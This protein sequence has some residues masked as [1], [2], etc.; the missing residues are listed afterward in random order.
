M[1]T[2]RVLLSRAADVLL[3]R[4]RDDRLDEEIHMHL[5][6]LTD[7]YVARGL[8]PADAAHAARRSFGRVLQTK[9]EFRAQR[10]LPLLETI[11][12][13]VRFAIRLLGRDRA[14][15][16]TAVLVLAL[17][18]GVNNML[19]AI[20]NAHTLRGLPIPRA[21]R[22]AAITTINDQNQD[23]GLSHP[24]YEQ[25]RDAV[26]SFSGIV[27][28]AQAPVIL[29]GDGAAA[30][31]VEGLYVSGDAFAITGDRPVLGR[32]FAA[33]DE[34]MGAAPVALIGT[35]TWRTRYHGDAAVVGR[36]IFVNGSPA[37]VVGVM[38]DRSGLPTTAVVW[39]PLSRMPGLQA[40]KRTDRGLRVFGRLRDGASMADAT[41]EVQVLADRWS[42]EHPDSNKN[43][44]APVTP[45]NDRYFGRWNDTVWLAFITAGGLIVL[46]S[47]ANVANLMLSRTTRR[48]REIAIRSSLGASRRRVVRQLLI[49]GSVLATIGGSLGLGVAIGGLQLFRSAIPENALPYWIDYSPD[50]TVITALV[51]VSA[52]TVIVFALLPA[53]QASKTDINRVLK[54]GGRGTGGRAIPRWTTVFLAAEFA[55]AVILMAQIAVSLRTR[56]PPLPTDRAI[57]T[58]Q[59]LTASVTLPDQKYR[60]P[61]ERL[62]FHRELT[63][64]LRALPDVS[65]SSVATAV[66]LMGG[67]DARIGVAD[68]PP[69]DRDAQQ[70][71]RTVAIG[72]RYFDTLALPPVRGREI[73]ETDNPAGSPAVV[74][75][76]E[77]AR[78]FFGEQDPVGRRI[79]ISATN[80]PEKTE[81]WNVIVGV[82]PDI[83]QRPVADPE[84]IVYTAYAASPSATVTLLIRGRT[85]SADLAARLKDE[86][87]ALDA[88][89][90][91]TR[92]QTMKDV[93]W[94]TQWNGRLSN[95]LI[96]TLTLIAA[97]L[98]IVGL[99]AVTMHAVGRQT[100]EIGVRMALGA[101]PPQI[102]RMILRQALTQLAIG[103]LAGIAC[104]WL[105]TRIFPSGSSSVS[106]SDPQS[107]AMVAG[108]LLVAAMVACVIPARRAITL[109]PV[110]AIRHE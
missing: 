33:A 99:Y 8:S 81:S 102:I 61:E 54:D 86:V 92:V 71:A 32:S 101:R 63:E 17:G 39:L 5:E 87:A 52:A 79:S 82:A 10:G 20:L 27:A 100:Q 43:V 104:T 28:F 34:R 38:D 4:R 48:A 65:S 37:T 77:F 68:H 80:A 108:I 21:D 110:A 96:L 7:E 109:D 59:V 26:K 2:L 36:S 67:P 78:V 75:N 47:S 57:D 107:L 106:A 24:E 105:W 15:S 13:D 51:S 95:R 83:R 12:Q 88:N 53:M 11:G 6:L 16:I 55:L 72:P 40:Q 90:P 9:E 60:T 46:I 76:Q 25:L 70:T 97:A 31:R 94:S 35:T 73:L 50:A 29:S 42:R 66:P 23:R 103:F 19:F 44:R 85:E 89:L 45:V 93:F 1:T 18:I 62:H 58:R 69:A 84:P 49:E 30:E 56:R 41:A 64:R 14:F 98:S 74:I 22:V 3:R 91:V